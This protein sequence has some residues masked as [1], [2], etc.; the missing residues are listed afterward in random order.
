MPQDQFFVSQTS[1]ASYYY[2]RVLRITNSDRVCQILEMVSCNHD[3]TSVGLPLIKFNS[4]ALQQRI[5]WPVFKHV[6]TDLSFAL[7]NSLS[8]FWNNMSLK[9][10][11]NHT[12]IRLSPNNLIDQVK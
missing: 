12:Y 7:L 9:N 10:Y 8:Y 1:K 4:Y 5:I 11:I 3:T 2:A 6:V